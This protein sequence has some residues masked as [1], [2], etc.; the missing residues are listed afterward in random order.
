MRVSVS[1]SIKK[2]SILIPF[3]HRET[4]NAGNNQKF[5]G[6]VLVRSLLYKY[7]VDHFAQILSADLLKN[8][9]SCKHQFHKCSNSSSRKNNSDSNFKLQTTANLL[10]STNLR[11]IET[12]V[13]FASNQHNFDLI[14]KMMLMK[15]YWL[16][17]NDIYIE[18]ATKSK[19][20]H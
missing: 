16:W 4:F 8:C 17:N 13:R 3:H 12:Q 6:S 9:F 7:L 5:L 15:Q 14:G 1:S 2:E 11:F 18:I 10:S 20:M 19:L